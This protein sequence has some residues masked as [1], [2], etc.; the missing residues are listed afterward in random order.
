MVDRILSGLCCLLLLS[1]CEQEMPFD[2]RLNGDWCIELQLDES[3]R[4]PIAVRLESDSAGRVL[5]V[6]NGDELVEAHELS[7]VGDTVVARFAVFDT[8]F[9]FGFSSDS[10][11]AGV[12]I[13]RSRTGDYRIPLYGVRGS[14]KLFGKR[15]DATTD[16]GGNWSVGFSPNSPEAYPAIGSFRQVGNDVEGTFLT[17][18]GDLRFL[19]GSVSGDSVF[20]SG[21]DGAHALLFKA[22]VQGDGDS[23]AGTF[24]SGIHWKE[25]WKGVRNEEARLPDPESLTWLRPGHKR[26]DFTFPDLNGNPVSLSDARFREKAVLVQV[27]GSWCPNCLDETNYLLELH[28]RYNAQ[29]LEIVALGFER[30]QDESTRIGHLKRMVSDR[31]IPYPVLLA[32]SASKADAADKLPMLN[33]VLS[34][35]TTVFVDRK[36]RVRRVFTGFSGPATG[37]SYVLFRKRTELLIEE[38]LAEQPVF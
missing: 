2:E 26:F 22:R 19:S 7:V 8:E 15:P 27:M 32:G 12:Y 35:P 14:H 37:D 18:T 28:K 23:I 25:H 30:G 16:I 3:H 29:G 9:R 17:T 24:W 11:L 1:A 33:H 34:F 13:D 10:T 6:R 4:L 31:D 36:G 21:F 38:M 20:L 5:Q